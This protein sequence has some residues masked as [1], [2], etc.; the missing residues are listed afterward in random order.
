M[1]AELLNRLTEAGANGYNMRVSKV[2]DER[3]SVVI[4]PLL[5]PMPYSS[6]KE[7]IEIHAAMQ[8]PLIVNAEIGELYELHTIVGQYLESFEGAAQSDNVKQVIIEQT[9]ASLVELTS[10]KASKSTA[11]SSPKKTATPKAKAPAVKATPA[12]TVTTPEPSAAPESA[13]SMD[14]FEALFASDN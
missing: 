13:V 10:S 8:R 12:A 14:D 1:I 9:A 7:A 11:K 2:G 4:N 6:S 3:V 5:D